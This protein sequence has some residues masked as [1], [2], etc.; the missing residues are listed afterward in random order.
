L[1]IWLDDL[2]EQ[3]ATAIVLADSQTETGKRLS[4]IIVDNAV[5]FLMKTYIENETQLIG[6][7]KAITKPAWDEIK[8][9][10]KKMIEFVFKN[11]QSNTASMTDILSYHNLRNDLY[12]G[13]K[14]LSVEAKTV[15][16]YTE[17]F[18]TLLNDLQKFKMSDDEW[19]KRAYDVSQ[20]VAKKEAQN[21]VIIT[22]SNQNGQT[23][24]KTDGIMKD[25]EAIMNSIYAFTHYFGTEPSLDDIE[26]ILARSGH[27]IERKVISKRL[28]H[29]KNKKMILPSKRWLDPTA[30]DK[31]R[32]KYAIITEPV[33]I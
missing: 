11:F 14:P 23:R 21:K 15:A 12:H 1:A 22:Y 17:Q 29:L 9:N 20:M 32:K 10:F 18:K 25:T 28:G 2:L 5:E 13:A 4:F 3:I 8:Q 33:T 6:T 27:A 7:G 19:R 26:S 31:L 24:L 30:V 16:K